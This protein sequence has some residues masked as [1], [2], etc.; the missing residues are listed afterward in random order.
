[1]Q[2]TTVIK[3]ITEIKAN[4][5]YTY[6]DITDNET[7]LIISRWYDCL[8]AYKDEQVLSAFRVAICKLS[9]P[10]TVADIIG[11][12]SRQERLLEPRDME[13]WQILVRAVEDSRQMVYVRDIGYRCMYENRGESARGIY[14]RLP[15]VLK[16]YIDFDSFC[17]VGGMTDEEL[18]F[19]RARF[20]KALPEIRETLRERK[21]A[22]GGAN[23]LPRIE[24]R[25]SPR[26]GSG[27]GKQS[28]TLKGARNSDDRTGD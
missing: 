18:R 20:L 19:E 23:V 24:E 12:I 6:K 8:K 28:E 9:T 16:E 14:D 26:L 22:G 10:P 2:K 1:M 5:R 4:Y 17:D 13:L 3:I 11:I 25:N 21:L 15:I 27:G 7:N